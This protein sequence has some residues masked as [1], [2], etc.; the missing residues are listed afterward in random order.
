MKLVFTQK[1]IAEFSKSVKRNIVLRYSFQT[2]HLFAKRATGVMLLPWFCFL[3]LTGCVQENTPVQRVEATPAKTVVPQVPAIPAANFPAVRAEQIRTQCIDGRR[4]ICGKVLKIAK[5]GL[6]VESGYTS[7]L[8][9]PLTESWIVPGT[10]PASRNPDVLEL[11]EP[12][13]PCIGLVFLTDISKRQ[14]VEKYDYVIL[15]GYPAG[16]YVYTPAPNVKK[17]IRKFSA[18]LDT[19][20][21]LTLQAEENNSR[22]NSL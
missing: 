18:G 13:T 12:G 22:T 19:A 2:G 15:M 11:N 6:V 10:V 9:P 21:R 14:K 1:H 8:R 4:L 7:L 16:E 3:I 17:T 20:V 5:D